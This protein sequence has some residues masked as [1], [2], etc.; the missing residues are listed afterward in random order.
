MLQAQELTAFLN[1]LRIKGRGMAKPTSSFLRHALQSQQHLHPGGKFPPQ[2]QFCY[3]AWC[4][5]MC[6]CLY[7][8]RST[9]GGEIS[10]LPWGADSNIP[11]AHRIISHPEGSRK[12]WAEEFLC[13]D[14]W[15]WTICF[16]DVVFA[17]KAA[18]PAASQSQNAG[19]Q[20]LSESC[21]IY[22][23]QSYYIKIWHLGPSAF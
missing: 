1:I 20:E 11:Q 16:R 12:E 15:H 4:H 17:T 23:N 8:S 13:D 21:S 7:C 22:D 9:R 19:T 3:F 10:A 6:L 14:R 5:N 2:P 18:H